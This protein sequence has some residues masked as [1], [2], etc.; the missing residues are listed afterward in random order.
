MRKLILV[1]TAAALGSSLFLAP[2]ASSAPAQPKKAAADCRV[3]MD[4][5]TYGASCPDRQKYRARA[6]CTNGKW[7]N[8]P[9]RNKWGW[10]YAYC[11]SIGS[12]LEGWEIDWA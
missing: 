7:V 10:S 6:Y 12:Y 5:R 4:T 9:W 1:T 11:S 8:G 3:W 2:T